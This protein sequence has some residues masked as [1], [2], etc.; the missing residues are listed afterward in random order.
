MPAKDIFHDC[1]KH[2]LIKDGWIVTDD[3][4]S[5]KIGK[6]DLFIDLAAEKILMAEKGTEKIAVE[7]KSF[8]G[9]SEVEDLKNA[10]GQYVLYEKIIK[11]QLLDRTLYL[12]I[13]EKTFN[14]LFHQEIGQILLEEKTLKLIIFNPDNEV[15][16]Q[17]IN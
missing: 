17:W 9:T 5:L 10:L 6:K 3:P 4:L 13:R 8:I 2:A 15:I 11:H 1:V 16:T 14:S 12:A 7:I